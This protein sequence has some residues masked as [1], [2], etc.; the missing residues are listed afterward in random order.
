MRKNNYTLILRVFIMAFVLNCFSI[1][2]AY[3]ESGKTNI[4]GKIMTFDKKSDYVLAEAL[5]TADTVETA[6]YG[7]FF[8][9]ANITDVSFKDGMPSYGIGSGDISLFYNYGDDI[10][11]A[12]INTWHLSEDKSKKA[13]EMKLDSNILKGA[14]IVQTS[15]DGINW[16]N[17]DSKTN[18]FSDV[19][20]RT[21]AIYT[22]TEVQLNNGCYYRVI[23]LYELRMKVGENKILFITTDKYDYKKVAEVYEFYAYNANTITPETTNTYTLGS[24]VRV[25]DFDS[26]SGQE[27]IDEDDPHR[28]WD[29]G[30]FYVSGYTADIKDK[31]DNVVFLKNVGDKV[32]LWFK[33]EQNINALN[34][35]EDL[36]IT[37]DKKGYD[38]YFEQ[39]PMNFGKGALFIRHTDRFNNKTDVIKYTNFLQANALVDADTKV[40]LFEEGDYEIAL[41]YEITNDKLI[42]KKAHYRIFFKFSV[43]NGNC[44]VYPFDVVTGSELTNS[45]ITENGFR[46]DLAKSKYLKVNVKR[47]TLREGADGLVEDIR[48]NGPAKDGAEYTDEG[49]YTIT[50]TNEYT[51]QTTVKKIYVGTNEL[52]RAHVTTGLAVSEIKNLVAEGAVINEDGTLKLLG[53]EEDI[54]PE[55]VTPDNSEDAVKQEVIT[56]SETEKDSWW[57][58]WS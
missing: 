56:E 48:F 14:Y 38:Q 40:Q 16:V 33:L 31:N 6:T 23:I 15:T 12:D 58:V 22:T 41:D 47:E 24:K 39:G 25:E 19:P 45:S 34:G 32:T 49:I 36:S 44:M 26:Y 1:M 29:L 17:S 11:N 3:A 51:E 53:E 37:A 7:D 52:L 55:I 30:E 21:D 50:V 20:V 46:L 2:P 9:E 43:R 42:N 8:I 27:P 5:S 35:N 28:G 18:I 10:L 57:K 13:N 4:S 54:A